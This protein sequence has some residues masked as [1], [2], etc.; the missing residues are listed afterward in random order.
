MLLQLSAAGKITRRKVQ[1]AVQQ[2]E[3]RAAAK[4]SLGAV[5]A[6]GGQT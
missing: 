3:V 4:V 1:L 5:A 2:R 6:G